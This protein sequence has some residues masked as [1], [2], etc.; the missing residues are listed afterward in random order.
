VLAKLQTFEESDDAQVKRM[1]MHTE[2]AW[3]P[4]ALPAQG[5]RDPDEHRA[6]WLGA[7]RAALGSR[8]SS[9]A[10]SI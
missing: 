2:R 1:G 6:K 5:A 10:L 3:Q 4:I 8:A 7:A 9:L